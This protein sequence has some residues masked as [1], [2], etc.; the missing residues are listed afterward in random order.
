M[1]APRAC[2]Q[3]KKTLHGRQVLY[4]SRQCKNRSSNFQHQIYLVQKQRGASRKWQ[5]IQLLGGCCR[6]CGYQVNLGALEFHHARGRKEFQLDMRAIA[7]RS[8]KTVLMEAKK[9]ELLCSNCHAEVHRPDLAIENLHRLIRSPRPNGL[10]DEPS[11]PSP[12]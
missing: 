12:E 3:C 5:L 6:R 9:C 4:C 1:E 11:P 10:R 7:N 8:W 2:V